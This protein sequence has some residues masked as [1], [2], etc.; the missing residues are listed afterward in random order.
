MPNMMGDK[1]CSHAVIYFE[2]AKWMRAEVLGEV[3]DGFGVA[4]RGFLDQSRACIAQSA[5]GLAQEA[6]DRAL[7]FV[8]N[9]KTFGK[10]LASRQAVQMR[11]AEM[12]DRGSGRTAPVSGCART[13]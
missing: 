2:A 6:L 8:R 9:R 11:L 10:A 3:G 1:G 5:V 13:V 7:T 4:V 12:A